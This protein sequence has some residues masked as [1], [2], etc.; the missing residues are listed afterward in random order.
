MSPRTWVA[1][2]SEELTAYLDR[3]LDPPD[4]ARVEA[5]LAGCDACR[6]EQ[7]RLAAVS[8]LLARA[9][10][11]P[12]P[13]P[14]FE[15]RFHARLASERAGERRVWSGLL[16]RKSWR[17]LAPGLGA[18]AAAAAVVLFAGPGRSRPVDDAFVAS[19]L[20]LFESYEAVASLDA[21]QSGE[22]VDVVT[23]LGELREGKP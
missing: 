3:A 14:T 12:P 20:D 16:D 18:A 11:A 9:P 15:A 2:P 5:H 17:W 6:A 13:S 19:H 1:H 7:A 4:A 22:D 8:R 21:V 23:H 10:V